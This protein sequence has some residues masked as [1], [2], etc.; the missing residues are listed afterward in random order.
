MKNYE[1]EFPLYPSFSIDHALRV[2]IQDD[3]DM[4]KRMLKW[5]CDNPE[6]ETF[7]GGHSGRGNFLGWFPVE[8]LEEL[9]AFFA[10]EE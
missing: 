4:V 5:L 2:E 1:E 10:E 7:R 8:H 6:I 9:N 3:Y